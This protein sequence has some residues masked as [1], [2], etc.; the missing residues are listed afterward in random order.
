MVLALLIAARGETVS[1]DDLT[2][3]L[4]PGDA[5]RSALNQVHRHVGELRRLLEPGLPPRTAGA[6]ILAIGNG[7]RLDLGSIESDFETFY[8]LAG[9]AKTAPNRTEAARLAIAALQTAAL[10]AFKDLP[11]EVAHH[12]RLAA[13][14]K[15]RWSN[16][17]E[18]IRLTTTKEAAGRLVQLVERVAAEAPLEEGLQAQLMGLLALSG[19]R[20]QALSLFESTREMLLDKLGIDPGLELRSAQLAILRENSP[21]PSDEAAPH[22]LPNGV[23]S[24]VERGDVRPV[25]EDVTQEALHG[26]GAIAVLSG[27]AGVGKTTL[28]VNWARSI[29]RSFPDGQLY[30]NLRG[31][32]EQGDSLIPEV[33]LNV[34][35]EQLGAGLQGGDLAERTSRFRQLLAGRR[36]IV[37]IDNARD[38]TQVRPLLSGAENSLTI[39]TSRNQLAG[40]AVREGARSIPL[41][42][43]NAEESRQLLIGR[44]GLARVQETPE[45]IDSIIHSCAGLP[46]ALA[47]AAARSSL[48]PASA[49]PELA[50]D[51][52]TRART[53][54]SL[55]ASDQDSV[56]SAFEW[57]YR[58]LG[59]NQARLFRLLAAHP[60]PRMSVLSVASLLEVAS[61][62]ARSLIA[63]LVGANMV[64]EAATDYVEVHDLLRMYS[65]ELFDLDDE[66][67]SAE[68]RLLEHYVRSTR[69]AFLQFGRAPSV[70]LELI[71]DAPD[72][73]EQFGDIS[74]ALQWYSRER[75]LLNALIRRA[76]DTGLHRHAA[77]IA[78]DWRPMNQM[79]DPY[80][81]SLEICEVAYESA[82]RSGDL[83]LIGE[84]ARDV[85]FKCSSVGD[86][87]RA[88]YLLSEALHCFT[89]LGDASGESN[90]YRNLS[91]HA[92]HNGDVAGQIEYGRLSVEAARKT[93][94]PSI[95]ALALGSYAMML[96][97][98][99]DEL[100][101]S[102]ALESLA[103]SDAAGLEYLSVQTIVGLS[104]NAL[105]RGDYAEA[106]E[107][108]LDGLRR[109]THEDP[110][111]HWAIAVV[112]VLTGAEMGDV[113]GVRSAL[114]RYDELLT[115]H[116]PALGEAFDDNVENYDKRVEVARAWLESQS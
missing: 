23:T 45:A 61:N 81:D 66:R 41:R 34:L 96:E 21:D 59:P 70:E 37:L 40:L 35:L 47:I 54:D 27:M 44:L 49:M 79:L 3:V 71:G 12:P 97:N 72:S 13:V 98:T 29:S 74:A 95:L 48:Q 77:L 94:E 19:R 109:A 67:T 103:V 62:E 50:N 9:A 33:A 100:M 93:A 99:D 17:A 68:L 32:D 92:N 90:T 57:S 56:R 31:Y 36:T 18:V 10:P 82:K 55:S 85:A 73:I 15:D 14:D 104:T 69:E 105:K 106:R 38:V 80:S 5:P 58:S 91:M 113:A 7:Y 2:D 88:S 108:A 43:W 60:G 16:A 63:D 114:E 78:L 46:L 102:V 52:A 89:L 107:H 8:R 42:R 26:N 83:T 101:H 84:L 6:H 115:L 111:S 112:L 24:F 20:A 76:H 110:V 25:L 86:N 64:L 28:A 65:D 87:Q 30:V 22:A 39:I 75:S 1:V 51:L 116:R 53:L 4:W 11:W